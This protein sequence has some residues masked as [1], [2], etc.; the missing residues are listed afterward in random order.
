MAFANEASGGDVRKFAVA[1]VELGLPFQLFTS[2]M[3]II[4]ARCRLPASITPIELMIA[5]FATSIAVS[6]K[7]EYLAFNINST[8]LSVDFI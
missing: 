7:H 2:R 3:A 8:N 1:T 4:A 6:G 5:F